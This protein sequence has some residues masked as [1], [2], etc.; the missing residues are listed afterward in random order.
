[1]SNPTMARF[2]RMGID[3]HRSPEEQELHGT[4][5]LHCTHGPTGEAEW[6]EFVEQMKA[7]FGLGMVAGNWI[8]PKFVD[9]HLM[10]T[11]AGILLW[12][13]AVLA[14]WRL[15]LQTLDAVH[16][17]QQCLSQ[18]FARNMV[19]CAD[20]VI[21]F[22][23]FEDDPAAHLPLP[24]CQVRDVLCYVHST[25]WILARVQA[26]PQAQVAWQQTLA[27]WSPPLQQALAATQ[28]RLSLLGK[29]PRSR[30]LGR[31]ALR[32]R[33]AWALLAGNNV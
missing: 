20:G 11:I 13:A 8:G 23:D 19:C 28:Q 25:A 7:L 12:G 29:L 22:I 16:G 1:M 33:M 9:R 15:G 21:G 32:L 24:L 2:G 17:H 6:N 27:Q 18:A 26:L 10:A 5:C 3:I 31:D 30:R 14:L 4:Q